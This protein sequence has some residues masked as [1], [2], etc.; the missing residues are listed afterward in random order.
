VVRHPSVPTLVL[1]GVLYA[2]TGVSITAGYHR[3]LAHRTY[4]ASA[5]VRWFFLAFA[6]ATFQ[7]S[8]LA[9]SADHRAHHADTDGPGDPTPSLRASGGLMPAGFCGVGPP[10]PTLRVSVICGPSAAFD[11]N[12]AFTP[13]SPSPSAWGSPRPSHRTWGDPWGGL[14]VAGFLRSAVLLQATLCVNSLAHTLGRR[15]YDDQTSAR[16][17]TITSLI[18]FGEGYHS[19][20]HRFPFDYRN[21]VSPWAY[22]PSNWLSGPWPA[23]AWSTRPAPPPNA[24]SLEPWP[25]RRDNA[26]Q[27]RNLIHPRVD[28]QPLPRRPR[29]R[30]LALALGGKLAG[31][32]DGRYP[33]GVSS[34]VG[35][36]GFYLIRGWP[37]GFLLAEIF[38]LTAHCVD[39]AE[40]PPLTNPDAVSRC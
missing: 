11:C 37:V 5:P 2:V 36:N 3:L 8:A 25:T 40:S 19:Y 16:D 10:R 12:G 35:R 30:D 33:A 18:T 29:S 26:H 23:S 20:H 17:S 38:Q 27:L 34:P 1:A 13:P 22:D 32:L 15:T 24:T 28:D 21:G 31:D 39:T 4:R 14:L 6:A 7:N 9:W